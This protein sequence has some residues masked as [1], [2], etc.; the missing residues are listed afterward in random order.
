MLQLSDREEE[1]VE[2]C[3]GAIPHAWQREILGSVFPLLN[4]VVPATSDLNVFPPPYLSLFPLCP[5]TSY[6]NTQPD[7]VPP[8]P[9]FLSRLRR[10]PFK[11]AV[12]F[13][14]LPYRRY[15]QRCSTPSTPPWW[16]ASVA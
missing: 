11:S 4:P 8:R 15:H 14:P 6:A 3:K 2:Y 16:R 10:N 13:C 9:S 5:N 1:M 12:P 7:Y